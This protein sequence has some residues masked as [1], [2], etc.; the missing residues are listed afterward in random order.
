M[1]QAMTRRAPILAILALGLVSGAAIRAATSGAHK[2]AD[3]LAA[4]VAS[5]FPDG[6]IDVCLS[7][8]E[9]TV[10]DLETRTTLAAGL[11]SLETTN[12]GRAMGIAQSG[13]NPLLQ[14]VH[15]DCPNSPK[16]SPII[17]RDVQ[18]DGQGPFQ[19]LPAGGEYVK[20]KGAID[21]QVVVVP[22]TVAAS[23]GDGWRERIA[24]F[25]FLEIDDRDF[26][27]LTSA[28]L[29]GEDELRDSTTLTR[30]LN[31]AVGFDA[32]PDYRPFVDG[33]CVVDDVK[34]C[35]P[36]IGAAQ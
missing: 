3:A 11:A 35:G 17:K 22:Q 31:L 30:I 33:R 27:H 29:V 9:G 24:P 23:V 28:V 4:Y 5:R 18:A 25:D 10:I 19:F 12:T 26:A 2:E 34:L 6:S 21:L 32:I 16:S 8:F 20:E 7:A 14:R 15:L 1:L 36:E 13:E